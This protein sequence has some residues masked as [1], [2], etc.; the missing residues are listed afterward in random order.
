MNTKEKILD[1]INNNYDDL[2]VSSIPFSLYS[3]KDVYSAILDKVNN[4]KQ[5][6]YALIW[7]DDN[8]TWNK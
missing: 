4:N 1:K 3:D 8:D 7:L 2:I 6:Y 5:N